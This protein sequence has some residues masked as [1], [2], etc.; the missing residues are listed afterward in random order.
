MRNSVPH[1]LKHRTC[2]RRAHRP[3]AALCI[4][5]CGIGSA[6]ALNIDEARHLL[7]RSGFGAAPHEIAAFL[8]LTRE[9]AVDRLLDGLTAAE[10]SPAPAF[11]KDTPKLTYLLRLADYVPY[12][13]AGLTQPLPPLSAAEATHDTHMG[14]QE[15]AQLRV[16]WLDQM[17]STP[18]PMSER[19]ALF[20]HG[21]FTSKYFDVEA[22]KLMYEQLQ[23][24]RT[25]GAQ[26]FASLLA[27]M[28]RDPAM[29]IFLD[30][31]VNTR[32]APNENLARE[33]LELFTL[34]V[35]HYQ[36]HDIK[37]F[38]RILAGHSVDFAA[39]WGYLGRPDEMDTGVKTFLGQTG[40]WNLEDAERILLA[41]PRTAQFISEKFY[42]EF[43]S[44]KTDMVQ[45][46]RLATILRDN[47]YEMHPFLRAMFLSDAFWSAANRS[48]LVKSPV[49][50]LVG[51]VRTFD[52]PS[53][54]LEQ[55]NTY[56]RLLGQELFEPPTVQGWKGGMNWLNAQT[57]AARADMLSMLWAGRPAGIEYV[58]TGP[59]DLIVRYSAETSNHARAPFR[60]KVNGRQV[61]QGAA[62]WPDD[63]TGQAPLRPP[64]WD[65]ASISRD[66]LP[67]DIRTVELLY[68]KE[69][70]RYPNLFV[71][72]IQVDG[73][74]VP[75]Y[76]STVEFDP[77]QLCSEEQVPR[78][79]LYCAGTLTFDLQKIAALQGSQ[80]ATLFDRANGPVNSVIESGTARLPL[81]MKPA[82]R[83]SQ[84]IREP[85]RLQ[86]QTLTGDAGHRRLQNAVSAAPPMQAAL[87]S[88]HDTEQLLH[89]LS[90]D[91]AYNLK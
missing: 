76:L 26:N 21:H 49:E 47:H 65:L 20:W 16:W 25:L 78:G 29:L 19:L 37:E 91:P 32:R 11:T 4:A 9:Q 39:S 46:N 27:A 15:M 53:P 5:A 88:A 35:G 17:I 80:E 85:L 84:A 89:A 55:I 40:P 50:L 77:K 24:I 52:V 43:V 38:A 48:Q 59:D 10:V 62:R 34:G 54:D 44:P 7:T 75:A 87:T 3:L 8:P 1:L 82:A 71:N 61:Y 73:K 79:M 63:A 57:V 69:P 30:N 31:A 56:A 67:N 70:G 13:M 2:R 41:D 6:W 83:T 22:P 81:A 14:M 36:E 90:L 72:W 28:L 23:K 45:V 64:M 58:N 42:Q 33:T 74:R 86:W 51:F 18:S 12:E 66:Q 60:I 68:D